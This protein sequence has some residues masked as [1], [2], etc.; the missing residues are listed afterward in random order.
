MQ[1]PLKMWNPERNWTY[2]PFTRQWRK[3]TF[4]F[5]I[6][7]PELAGT[8]VLL[9]LFAIAQPDLFRTQLWHIG[10]V[11][12]FN[13]NPA[14][15]LYAK[16]NHDPHPHVPF[17]WSLDL[18]NYNVG[19]SVLSLF[20]LLAKL[21]GFIMRVWTPIVG[22]FFSLSMTVM[23]AVSVYGQMGPD[24]YDPAHPSPV[25]WYIRYGCWP[26]EGFPNDAVGS[27]RMAKGTFAATVFQLAIY[28]ICLGYA[29]YNMIPTKAE[30]EEMKQRKLNK[31]VDDDSDNGAPVDDDVVYE[32]QPQMMQ[33]SYQV[34]YTPRTQ[35]FHALDRKLPLRGP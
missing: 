26:A 31:G 23:Y 6:M 18:T 15:I 1:G 29:I 30:K 10:Y 33:Q 24:Y 5:L 17:V 16:A 7:L 3:R 2:K 25:A 11:W 4:M 22:V 34:P 20:V 21:V 8:V 35:A 9:V 28:V 12:G 32:M 13:S 14:I 19:I 27:C